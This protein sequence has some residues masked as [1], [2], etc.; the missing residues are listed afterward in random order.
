M[1]ISQVLM[2]GVEALHAAD[3]STFGRWRAKVHQW[4]GLFVVISLMGCSEPPPQGPDR[5]I[6]IVVDTLRADRVGAYGGQ[7]ATPHMDELARSGQKFSQARSSFHLTTMSMASLF[8]GRVPSLETGRKNRALPYTSE[9]F[10][11]MA[12]FRT[13]GDAG[14]IPERLETLA[15]ALRMQG[16]W[17]LAVVG[18]PLLFDP[19]GYS[20]GFDEWVEVG[21]IPGGLFRTG[22]TREHALERTGKQINAALFKALDER[23]S[24]HF[25]LFAHYLDVHDWPSQEHAYAKGVEAFDHFLGELLEYLEAE[26]LLEGATVVVT[27]DH[28]EELGEKH[29]RDS[30][31]LHFGNPSYEP[32][33]RIPLIVSPARFQSPD[34]PVRGQDLKA[35]ILSLAEPKADAQEKIAFQSDREIFISEQSFQTLQMGR[36]KSFWPRDG[37]A[38]SLVDLRLDPGETV[39]RASENAAVLAR[40]RSRLD[41]IEEEHWTSPDLLF[42]EFSEEDRERLRSLGYLEQLGPG[43]D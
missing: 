37:S 24:D 7:A 23:P 14:C 31:G 36:W 4:I 8:T 20:Q 10:C 21:R 11:G 18:N 30:L 13:D 42:L 43:G 2:D 6:L 35:M 32:V 15:E 1:D 25:F 5:I 26:S 19:Y 33:L 38:P 41:E 28:G 9:T 16:Y 34:R 40:H 27:S 17:T 22:S 3:A 29:F 12:R 39:D